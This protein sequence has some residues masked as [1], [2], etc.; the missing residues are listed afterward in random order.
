MNKGLSRE[1]NT[2]PMTVNVISALSV[3]WRKVARCSTQ[4]TANSLLSGEGVIP[5]FCCH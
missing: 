1:P 5:G 2:E 4:A 3:L